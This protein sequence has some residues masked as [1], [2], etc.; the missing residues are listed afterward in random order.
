MT[1]ASLDAGDGRVEQP[2]LAR[3]VAQRH[4]V[5]AAV[6]A[7]TPR[8]PNRS[9]AAFID[10]AS[11]RSP[12]MTPTRLGLARL[13]LG[14][15]G[16]ERLGPGRRP[17]LAALADVGPV[18][19]LARQAVDGVAGL[20]A[21]PLLVDVLVGA[22]QHAQDRRAARVDPDRRAQRVHHVD[23]LGLL[24]LPRPGVEGLGLGVSAPT[25]HRSMML[26]D[27]SLSHGL[28]EI[29]RD[30]DVFAAGDETDLGNAGDLGD[31]PHAAGALD[32]AGHRPS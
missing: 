24:Q 2:A 4:A 31:E 23:A 13:Q 10:S 7:L 11:C 16:V 14:G 20:V 19:P 15:D 22:R 30:L 12:A 18:Q 17:Q 32:A 9:S 26:A 29:G 1:S 27:S 5:L 8:P 28:V 6:G 3:A 21:D 25:G